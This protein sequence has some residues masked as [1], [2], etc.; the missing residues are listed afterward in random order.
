M[1]EPTVVNTVS[2]NNVSLGAENESKLPS[3]EVVFS[4]LQESSRIKIKM[5]SK[6]NLIT[7]YVIIVA[8]YTI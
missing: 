5:F 1:A 7:F 3:K 6:K 2:K 8:Q 4:F